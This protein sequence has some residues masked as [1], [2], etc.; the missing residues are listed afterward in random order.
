MAEGHRWG[1]Q[2]GWAENG[3]T[4]HNDTFSGTLQRMDAG[5]KILENMSGKVKKSHKTT[6]L[7]ISELDYVSYW[8]PVARFFNHQSVSVLLDF[9]LLE[10]WHSCLLG[11]MFI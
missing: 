4:K 7:L 6:T 5:A 10:R 11:K 8:R 1:I 3:D 2:A 9:F